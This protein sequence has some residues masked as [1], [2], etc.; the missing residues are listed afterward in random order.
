MLLG[1]ATLLL[2]VCSDNI[3]SIC[4]PLQNPATGQARPLQP[5]LTHV[6]GTKEAQGCACCLAKTKGVSHCFLEVGY[7]C[8]CMISCFWMGGWVGTLGGTCRV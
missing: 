6:T 4:V 2:S 3:D 5:W 8:V 7:E 1:V